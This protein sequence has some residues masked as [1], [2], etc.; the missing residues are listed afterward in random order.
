MEIATRVATT[1]TIHKVHAVCHIVVVADLNVIW[2]MGKATL[3]T[4][5][6]AALKLTTHL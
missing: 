6:L 3:V 1:A 4:V 2:W 5:T